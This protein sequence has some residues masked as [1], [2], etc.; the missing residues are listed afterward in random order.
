MRE[1]PRAIGDE[2]WPGLADGLDP[3]G[4]EQRRRGS[5]FDER[6][7]A[8]KP[9]VLGQP[10]LEPII[11][12]VQVRA[13]DLDS[14]LIAA[15]LRPDRVSRDLL[16]VVH[17]VE[18]EETVE[19]A[20]APP[21]TAFRDPLVRAAVMRLQM[22]N[23]AAGFDDRIAAVEQQRELA[24]RPMSL[25]VGEERFGVVDIERA[26][27]ER[28]PV[29]VERDQRFLRVGREGMAEECKHQFL[30]WEP[31][32]CQPFAAA[33]NTASWSVKARWNAGR[34]SPRAT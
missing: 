3:I 2:L 15:P 33:L 31:T 17:D 28:R 23:D 7:L 13:G 21:G 12:G 27:I 20:D 10:S 9:A 22:L 30:L 18:V 14:I 19:E 8:R 26:I 4:I 11:G 16:H 34:P 25:E 29:G 1:E 6:K 32:F 5:T 24:E